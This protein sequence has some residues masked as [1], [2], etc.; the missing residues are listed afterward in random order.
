MAT[1]IPRNRAA[2]G[3]DEILAVT[4]GRVVGA[5]DERALSVSGVRSDTR[6]T[7]AGNLFVA[8]RGL[9]FDGHEHLAAAA[10]AGAVLAL[11]ERRAAPVEGL[12]QLEVS[13]TLE[14]LRALAS[15]HLS[16]WRKK[17]G[18]V[19]AI[20]G[21]AGKTT[22]KEAVAAILR[23]LGLSARASEGNLN[24]LIGAPMTTLS[25]VEADRYAVLELGTSE[26][27]ELPK[28]AAMVSPD[29][30]IVTSI[31]AAHSQGLGSIEAIAAEKLALFA[32]TERTCIG[33]Y[34]DARVRAALMAEEGSIGYG[35]HERAALRI[36]E[37]SLGERLEQRLVLMRD[38]G[39]VIS[40]T[41]PLLGE[42]GALAVAAAVA[43][44]EALT[45]LALDGPTVS[46][47]LSG[48]DAGRRLRL[49]RAGDLLILD[50]SYN[51][52]PASARSSLAVAAELSA[53]DGR[54]LVLVLGEMR[55]LGERSVADH[56]ALGKLAAAARPARIIAIA[57]DARHLAEAAAAEG[58]EV[59]FVDD[60]A[61]AGR[62]A[63]LEV[64]SGDI[65]LVKGSRSIATETVVDAL[66]ETWAPR[67]AGAR[68]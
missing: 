51:S 49:V 34:D 4:G 31:S 61:E 8:L 12:T 3:L 39:I 45:G 65:I 33:N 2:F 15:L 1:P 19:L 40:V 17:G 41:S 36:E 44:V 57:G 55:E 14:A 66:V 63:A 42:A 62:L 25:L 43:G 56:V 29:V 38:G 68:A 46:E 28:L 50:D 16:R 35:H 24:N 54:R 37:R 7:E 48:F 21:S 9:R 10:R 59:A 23:R 6:T 13:S 32:R 18:R 27:G 30:S 20:T 52:N 11:V 26:R 53:R 60:A 58:V 5:L 22:T 47:A 67:E 64:R